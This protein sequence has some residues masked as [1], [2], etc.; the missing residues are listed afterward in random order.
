MRRTYGTL[1]DCKMQRNAGVGFFTRPSD[2]PFLPQKEQDLLGRLVRGA[3]GG[4]NG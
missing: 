3:V 1:N 2:I 4:I